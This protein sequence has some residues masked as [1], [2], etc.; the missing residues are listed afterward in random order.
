VA[1]QWAFMAHQEFDQIST[2]GNKKGENVNP[3]SLQSDPFCMHVD[4][5]VSYKEI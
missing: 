2:I 3:I 1:I 4:I 5:D